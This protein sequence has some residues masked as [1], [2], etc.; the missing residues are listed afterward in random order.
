MST[1]HN[2]DIHNYNDI[3]T[4][5]KDYHDK[6]VEIQKKKKGSLEK[7]KRSVY[8]NYWGPRLKAYKEDTAYKF[9]LMYSCN[10]T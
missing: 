2:I 1:T 6:T 9:N 5:I 8:L 3:W 4:D 7:V 10:K